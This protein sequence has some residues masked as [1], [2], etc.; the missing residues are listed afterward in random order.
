MHPGRV[1][2][3]RPAKAGRPFF[4]SASVPAAGLRLDH[5]GYAG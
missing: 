1:E 3:G 2:K 4:A 5:A